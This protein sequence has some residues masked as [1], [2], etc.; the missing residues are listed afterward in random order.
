MKAERSRRSDWHDQHGG[1][2]WRGHRLCYTCGFHPECFTKPYLKKEGATSIHW[3]EDEIESCAQA[4]NQNPFCSALS[5]YPTLVEKPKNTNILIILYLQNVSDMLNHVDTISGLALRSP[6][7][8]VH[9]LRW[10]WRAAQQ[11][12]QSCRRT[13][14][15]WRLG[16]FGLFLWCHGLPCPCSAKGGNIDIQ[17]NE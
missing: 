4:V 5:F 8:K 11:K 3:I 17:N 15:S 13:I 7:G 9:L 1:L 6:L 14:R 10:Y 2:V 16:R 12:K